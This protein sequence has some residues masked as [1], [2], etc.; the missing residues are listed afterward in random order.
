MTAQSTSWTHFCQD[1]QT[2]IAAG[3]LCD[4]CREQRRHLHEC[5]DRLAGDCPTKFACACP[6]PD[7]I[8]RCKPCQRVYKDWEAAM[9]AEAEE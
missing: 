3:L 6:D 9:T 1:C 7:G 4:S 2:P 5:A 8:V